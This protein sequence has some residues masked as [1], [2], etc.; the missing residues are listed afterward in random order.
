MQKGRAAVVAKM[1]VPNLAKDVVPRAWLQTGKRVGVLLVGECGGAV[2]R[3]NQADSAN[4]TSA[5]SHIRGE[6][7]TD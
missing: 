7:A 5:E 1:R 6:D 3:E 2:I 4:C